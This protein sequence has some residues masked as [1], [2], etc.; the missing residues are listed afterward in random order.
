MANNLYDKLEENIQYAKTNQR[1]LETE[2][3]SLGSL[4]KEN[5]RY[6]QAIYADTVKIRR[7]MR[8]RMIFNLIWLVI[9]LAPIILA[10]IYLPPFFKQF[11]ELITDGQSSLDFLNQLKNLK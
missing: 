6:S 4:L 9:V 1:L 11:Q 5:L 3:E 7:Y 10:F 8:W 2:Q